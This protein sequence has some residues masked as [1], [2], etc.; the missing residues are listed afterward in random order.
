MQNR[1]LGH[2][3]AG[4]FLITEESYK[5]V[6]REARAL[7]STADSRHLQPGAAVH[8]GEGSDMLRARFCTRDPIRVYGYF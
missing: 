7:D 2:S 8:A 6:E 5:G 4:L 3:W 1:Q